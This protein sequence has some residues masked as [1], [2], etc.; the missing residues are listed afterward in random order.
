MGASLIVPSIAFTSSNS[1]VAT[2]LSNWG[3]WGS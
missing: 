2:R 3:M 1:V